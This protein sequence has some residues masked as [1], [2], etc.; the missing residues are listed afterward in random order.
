MNSY[1]CSLAWINWPAKAVTSSLLMALPCGRS[2]AQKV[3]PGHPCR[4]PLPGSSSLGWCLSWRPRS[5]PE[6]DQEGP[7]AL[8]PTMSCVS[9]ERRAK[10]LVRKSN[11]APIKPHKQGIKQQL[12]FLSIRPWVT[13][14]LATLF[15]RAAV[16][17]GLMVQI[18]SSCDPKNTTLSEKHMKHTCSQ[19]KQA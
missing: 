5:L 18:K 2:W 9:M 13:L 12:L 17:V 3:F 4:L 10:R 8:R 7:S 6:W 19:N 1:W 11:V 15:G 14:E 16:S